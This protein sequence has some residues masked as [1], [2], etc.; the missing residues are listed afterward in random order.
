MTAPIQWTELLEQTVYAQ[1]SQSAACMA[2]H[3]VEARLCRWLL[4]ARDLADTD[5]A[6]IYPRVSCRDARGQA[7]ERHAACAHP[8]R[9]GNDKIFQ[10]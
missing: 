3:N 4:R 9:R 8:P 1:A 10:R 2:A 7:H 5:T 6:R